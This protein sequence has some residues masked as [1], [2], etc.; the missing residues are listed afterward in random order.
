MV[1][2]DHS[3]LPDISVRRSPY[4]F[5]RVMPTCSIFI[6]PDARHPSFALTRSA[7][8]RRA[9]SQ[10]QY[11]CPMLVSSGTCSTCRYSFTAFLRYQVRTGFCRS[12]RLK[13]PT[14]EIN[15]P[16][17]C[18]GLLFVN[19]VIAHQQKGTFTIWTHSTIATG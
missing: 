16:T 2:E 8:F 17:N 4:Y 18:A 9:C 1:S 10:T 12:E 7:K 11:G 6:A 15:G 3:L 5:F 13:D 14:M 19:Q